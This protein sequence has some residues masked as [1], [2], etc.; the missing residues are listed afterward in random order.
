MDTLGNIYVT[1]SGTRGETVPFGVFIVHPDG[2]DHLVIKM[3]LL[4]Q[5]TC[6]QSM[7]LWIG[8]GYFHIDVVKKPRKPPPILVFTEPPGKRS[9]NCLGGQAMHNGLFILNMFSEFFQCLFSVGCHMHGVYSIWFRVNRS[10][11]S[12]GTAV[13]GR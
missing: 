6:F 9:H 4:Q 1:Y 7:D 3:E 5:I 10:G 13:R 11:Y 2:I 12:S 8:P